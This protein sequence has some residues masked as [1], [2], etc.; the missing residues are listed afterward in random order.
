MEELKSIQGFNI[1]HRGFFVLGSSPRKERKI[2]SKDLAKAASESKSA[3]GL[4]ALNGLKTKN[5]E[6]LHTSTLLST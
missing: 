4:F 6:M 5:E 2:K 3:R 1:T